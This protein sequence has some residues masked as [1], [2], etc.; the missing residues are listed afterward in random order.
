MKWMTILVAHY[1]GLVQQYIAP[2]AFLSCTVKYSVL[3]P[4]VFLLQWQSMLSCL[5]LWCQYHAV[6]LLWSLL[7][8]VLHTMSRAKIGK[9]NANHLYVH[10][11]THSVTLI[12][13]EN[14]TSYEKRKHNLLMSPWVSYSKQVL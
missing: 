13:N 1:F 10:C 6:W 7:C 4:D 12:S 5:W 2:L 14:T 8:L 9:C 3:I 11:L